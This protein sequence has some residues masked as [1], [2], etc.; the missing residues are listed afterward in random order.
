M[1][2]RARYARS[3]SQAH[4][5]YARSI[6]QGEDSHNTFTAIRVAR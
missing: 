1:R 6:T 4:M 2:R 3:L 5:A